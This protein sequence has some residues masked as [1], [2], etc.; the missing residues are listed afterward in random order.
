MIYSKLIDAPFSVP[1]P[2][3]EAAT[4][5]LPAVV[6]LLL[7]DGFAEWHRIEPE[8]GK[9]SQEAVAHYHAIF[10]CL[11]RYDKASDVLVFG[12][13]CTCVPFLVIA[14]SLARVMEMD[15]KGDSDK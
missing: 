9:I 3:A 11:L 4:L 12:S 14:L 13:I 10:D 7:W 15:V 1:V 6:D 8:Q 5:A 2:P